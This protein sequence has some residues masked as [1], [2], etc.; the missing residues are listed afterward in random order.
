MLKHRDKA[1]TNAL[2]AQAVRSC[3]D[4]G[5]AYL[6]YENFA[7]GKKKGDTLSHFK[8]TNG[9]QRVDLPRYYIPLTPLGAI[10]LRIGLHRGVRS[11]VPEMV[12]AKFRQLRSAWYA[13][14]YRTAD[15]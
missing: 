4:R 8:E 6:V 10:A 2:L 9:F 13:R 11:A 14:R 1:P 5:I 7:Y 3:A 15:A 12:M